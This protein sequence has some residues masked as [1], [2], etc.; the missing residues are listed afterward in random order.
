[1]T[2][3]SDHLTA[4][5]LLY[6][7]MALVPPAAPAQD[8]PTISG[9]EHRAAFDYL[10]GDWA[11]TGE[12]LG[13]N[14]RQKFKGFWTATRTPA[15]GTIVDEYRV[16]DDSGRTV[17]VTTTLRRFHPGEQRWALVSIEGNGNLAEGRGWKDGPDMRIEQDYGGGLLR[18]RYYS[19][20]PDR[21]SWVGAG[22]DAAGTYREF[23]WIEA[24][25][26]GPHRPGIMA[27]QPRP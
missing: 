15:N 16:V 21:F 27:V 11:F 6:P 7:L 25:R 1:M 14:G 4:A 5:L 3:R 8:S 17:Y 2:S 12:R 22:P 24:R 26:V 18:F 19:I 9:A 20:Q 23:Q 10:L 13:P